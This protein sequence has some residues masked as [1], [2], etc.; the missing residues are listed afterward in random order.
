MKKNKNL[1]NKNVHSKTSSGKPLP[2]NFNYSR[3]NNHPIIRT[4][5]DNHH[6]KEIHE[7]SNKTELLDHIVEKVSIKITIQDQIKP[8]QIFV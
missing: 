3:N 4:I 7:I 5:E 2:N 1:P 6:T 8:T